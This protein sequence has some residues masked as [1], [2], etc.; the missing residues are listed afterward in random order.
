MT[1]SARL[2]AILSARGTRAT[3]VRGS[4][5]GLLARVA[6]IL[7]G[8]LSSVVLARVLAPSGYGTY[9]Y[10]YAII[11]VIMIP[12]Q[13]GLPTLILRE[14]ARA[15]AAED[16][17][18]LRG[19]WRW[20]GYVI[21]GGAVLAV[22]GVIAWLAFVGHDMAVEQRN[23]LLWGL[24]LIPLM[25]LSAARA[26]ALSGLRLPVRSHLTDQ[27]LRPVVLSSLLLATLGIGVAVDPARAMMFHSIAAVLA[28]AAGAMLL[29]QARSA[30]MRIPGPLRMKHRAWAMALLPLSALAAVQIVNQ[31]ADLIMLGIFRT[32]TEVGLYR[33]AVSSASLAAIGL[34]AMGLVL[35]GH[36]THVLTQ[37]DYVG[38]Q[39]MLSAAALVSTAL[40]GVVLAGFIVVGK[41]ML[42]LIFGPDYIGAYPALVILTLAQLV[43]GFFGVNVTVLNLSGMERKTLLAV[44]SAVLLNIMLNLIFIPKYGGVAAAYATLFSTFS[45][46]I[47]CWL[48]IKLA[49]RVDSTLLPVVRKKGRYETSYC[50]N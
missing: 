21:S 41:P 19:I 48:Q 39:R 31:S 30:P 35:A 27:V 50:N 12:V 15:N 34:T 46:N 18:L 36:I 2:R 40:T 16:W 42:S 11:A 17:S 24:P 37:K 26:S 38:L 5:A 23:T 49:L 1:L 32:D 25:A 14:T 8:L 28:F 29:S 45:W 44:A 7:A 20:S 13:M 3:L 9:S 47:A 33:I 22:C 4:L 43:S 6:A 10:A